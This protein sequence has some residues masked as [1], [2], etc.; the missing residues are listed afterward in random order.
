MGQIIQFALPAPRPAKAEIVPKEKR[1]AVPPIKLTPVQVAWS[2]RE[3][4]EFVAQVF[5]EHEITPA[6]GWTMS[7]GCRTCERYRHIW[8]NPA[9]QR[10]LGELFD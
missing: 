4:L 2:I 1:T 9:V 7:C 3:K 10:I 6:D 8:L 5:E